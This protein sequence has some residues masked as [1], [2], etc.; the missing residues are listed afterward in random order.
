[1]LSLFALLVLSLVDLLVDA[2]SLVD[3]LVLSLFAMLV[4]L[5]VLV[6]RLLLVDVEVESLAEFRVID[7]LILLVVVWLLPSVAVIVTL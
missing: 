6:E 4:D 1:M 7:H 3:L 2:L 5:T